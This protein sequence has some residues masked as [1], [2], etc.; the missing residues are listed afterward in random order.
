MKV[1]CSSETSEHLRITQCYIPEDDNVPLG[2]RI[3]E[4][5]Y[6]VTQGL[7]EKSE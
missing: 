7:L 2:V 6:D 4:R 5:K 3:E 1:M